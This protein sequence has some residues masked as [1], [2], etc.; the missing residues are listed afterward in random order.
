MQST[1]VALSDIVATIRMTNRHFDFRYYVATWDHYRAYVESTEVALSDIVAKIRM[2][3][4]IP[5]FATMSLRGITT[6]AYATCQLTIDNPKSSPF[7]RGSSLL[8]HQR[9]I[10]VMVKEYFSTLKYYK[11]YSFA[12]RRYYVINDSSSE[13]LDRHLGVFEF[14]SMTSGLLVC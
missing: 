4:V 9:F 1:E 13:D 3:I 7:I 8:R 5:I 12:D 14:H 10:V 2:T 6:G 11:Y